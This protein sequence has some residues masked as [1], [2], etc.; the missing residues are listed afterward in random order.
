MHFLDPSS[1]LWGREYELIIQQITI[2]YMR[3]EG[4]RL[5]HWSAFLIG[6]CEDAC[7]PRPIMFVCTVQLHTH[8]LQSQSI[9]NAKALPTFA[10]NQCI[11]AN[12]CVPV[13]HAR[14]VKFA[15]LIEWRV[16]NIGEFVLQE[17]APVIYHPCLIFTRPIIWSVFHVPEQTQ[18]IVLINSQTKQLIS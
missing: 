3:W 5:L 1:L 6:I 2:L 16:Q 9:K 12:A 17:S 15:V 10:I 14:R 7:F 13:V 4:I 11:T 8:K 18:N